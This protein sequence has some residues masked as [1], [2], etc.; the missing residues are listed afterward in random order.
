MSFIVKP[1]GT[2]N[3]K[4]LA[5]TNVASELSTEGSKFERFFL[6]TFAGV[7]KVVDIHGTPIGGSAVGGW[8]KGVRW[9]RKHLI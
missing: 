6:A 5:I 8:S 9:Y 3:R 4:I 1:T 7:T 2:V